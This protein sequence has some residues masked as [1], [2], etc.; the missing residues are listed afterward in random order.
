MKNKKILTIILIILLILILGFGV[1]IIV[2]K[3]DTTSKTLNVNLSNLTYNDNEEKELKVYSKEEF[4][5][6]YNDY[7]NNNLDEVYVTEFLFDG[8][9]MYKTYD[10]DDFIEGGN[11]TEVKPLEITTINI[12]TEGDI[13]FTGE[14]TGGMIALDTNKITKDVNIILNGVKLD[15]DSKKAPAIYVYNKDIT[16]TGSKVTIKTV[17]GT[18]NYIEGG[19]LKKVSLLGSDELS[20]YTNRYSGETATYYST[21]T[22]YYGIYTSNEID[23][24]LFAKVTADNEDLADGDPYYYYKASGVI[25]S[26]ID[27]YFEGEGYLEVTSK[28]K[29]G[30]ETKGNLEFVGGTGD[31]TVYAEDDCLNTTTDKSENT[32]ARNTLTIDVNSLTAV[33]SLEAEEGDAIDSNGTLTING[34]TIIALAKPGQDAGIDSEKGIYLNGGTV[35]ATGDMLDAISSDSKKAFVVFSFQEKPTEKTLITLLDENDNPVFAYK[36]DRTYSNL[37]YSSSSL[38]EGTYYLYK[39]G[40][41]TGEETNRLYTNITSYIKGVQ[42]GCSS[43][44][45]Q[46]GMGMNGGQAPDMNVHGTP[47]EKTDGEKNMTP[48]NMNDN[49][50]P[51]EK[52]S[53]DNNMQMPGGSMPQG[54]PTN[55]EFTITAGQNQFSGI[56]VLVEE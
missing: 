37:I 20:N 43:N 12:N 16:Y 33:V 1:F 54:S 51:P 39:D 34:G 8:V 15:T 50:T 42:L 14:L 26:D 41:I 18:E 52:P 36:T 31:Y 53:G 6:F 27:L 9:G 3:M 47:P 13:T 40:D 24:I 28:N 10:L 17:K 56:G 21:Y 30:I 22:N 32:Y 23:N 35:L 4:D 55:N 5:V 46:G 38:K 25:S 29:E 2:K 49:G 7:Q 48:P 45:I 19:K 44:T 11:N